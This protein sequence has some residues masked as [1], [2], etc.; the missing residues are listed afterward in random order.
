MWNENYKEVF[1]PN[2]KEVEEMHAL[3]SIL[4]PLI[5]WWMIDSSSAALTVTQHL[6][7][8]TEAGLVQRISSSNV[9][10]T[11][12]GDNNVLLQQTARFVM[13]G[14]DKI[15]KG[16]ENPYP[17][18]SYLKFEDFDEMKIET[19]VDFRS[20]DF[21]EKILEFRAAK[22]AM[23]GA[24][25]IQQQISQDISAFDA[26]NNSIPFECNNISRF[27][28]ELY[29]HKVGKEAILNCP[30]PKNREFLRKLCL[31]TTSA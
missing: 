4:K 7:L 9:Q 28:G 2:K 1:N 26:W 10:T 5:T 29:F 18:L 24:L 8:T 15:L 11:W 14:I 30:N 21:N 20:I 25:F 3:I 13:K 17:T 27:Y 19:P 12:E 16:E 6:G 22:A 31:F 23:E